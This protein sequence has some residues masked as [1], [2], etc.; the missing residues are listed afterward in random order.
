[1]GFL[2]MLYVVYKGNMVKFLEKRFY[3]V[4]DYYYKAGFK[5]PFK[6]FLALL[7]FIATISFIAP[8]VSI[9]LVYYLSGYPLIISFIAGMALGIIT[10]SIA[11]MF[12]MYYPVVAASG[13]GEK[14]NAQTPYIVS[15]LGVLAAAGYSPEVIV[16]KY[17]EK[18]KLYGADRE[19]KEVFK[20]ISLGGK[21]VST[22]LREVSLYTPSQILSEVFEGFAGI[23]ETGGNLRE[24]FVGETERITRIREAKL[25]EILN[26]LSAVAEIYIA[27]VVVSPLVFTTLF[28]IMAAL[29]GFAIDP[30][31]VIGVL[32]YVV[33][34]ALAFGIIIIIESILS[35]M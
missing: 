8:L 25:K 11:L 13:R 14:L 23:A 19:F 9:T 15:Y 33:I 12:T 20:R 6:L 18:A 4:K 22:A 3:W 30:Y 32:N 1:M 16:E 2:E 7:S 34:P 27:L 10:L 26:S 5:K 17:V 21:D 24:Y 29:G 28:G 31:F 35:K